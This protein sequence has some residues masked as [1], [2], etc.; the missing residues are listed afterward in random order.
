MSSLIEVFLEP[1]GRAAFDRLLSKLFDETIPTLC[2]FPESGRAF[3][4][5]AIKSTKVEELVK[6][7]R[8]LI[9]KDNI[10]RECLLEDH[11]VLYLVRQNTIVFLSVKHHRQLSFDLTHFW[12]E[13]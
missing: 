1:E 10:L 5:R 4:N 2:R 12:Q 3:L 7:L 6:R 8:R 13:E 11:P 9:K